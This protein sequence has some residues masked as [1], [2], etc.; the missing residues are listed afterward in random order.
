KLEQAVEDERA[1]KYNSKDF[2]KD[3]LP[4]LKH[5]LNVLKSIWALWKDME[6]D[7]KLD[8]FKFELVNNEILKDSKLVIFTESKETGD[9]IYENLI[10]EYPEQ[11][12]FYSGKG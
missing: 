5:D 12:F 9:Y 6:K 2:R 11:V 3:Y 8:K 10:Q 1:Q 7:P 4:D